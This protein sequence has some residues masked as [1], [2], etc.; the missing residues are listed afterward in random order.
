MTLKKNLTS[1]YLVTISVS[2]FQV[3]KTEKFLLWTFQELVGPLNEEK[4][5]SLSSI[6]FTV[7]CRYISSHKE[8]IER[9]KIPEVNCLCPVCENLELLLTG[10]LTKNCDSIDIPTKCHD[11][12]EK[13]ACDPKTQVC[14]DKKYTS[15]HLETWRLLIIVKKLLITHGKTETSITKNFVEEK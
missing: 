3:D 6:S 2:P 5:G 10:I 7:L 13:I 9:T 11:L 4:D 14:V 15:V 1:F 8:Y 12:L